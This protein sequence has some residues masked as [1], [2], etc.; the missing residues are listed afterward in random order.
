MIELNRLD[1]AVKHA[2]ELAKRHKYEPKKQEDQ[3]YKQLYFRSVVSLFNKK[4]K[5]KK[6]FLFIFYFY[7]V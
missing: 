6:V 4:D 1:E 3:H 5:I 7:L 2:E